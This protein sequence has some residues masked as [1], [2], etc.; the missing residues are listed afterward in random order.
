[1][2]N[3]MNIAP[4]RIRRI[5]IRDYKCIDELEMDFPEPSMSWD[6]D[7]LAMGA[8][9]G[10]GKTAVMECCGWLLLA[11]FSEDAGFAEDE[12]G[13]RM[14]RSSADFYD[15]FVR[16]GCAGA[17]IGGEFVF[18]EFGPDEKR[19]TARI[20]IDRKDGVQV[21]EPVD[22]RDLPAELSNGPAVAR[23]EKSR[24]VEMVSGL[25][26]NPFSGS[27]FLFLHSYRKVREIN[28]SLGEMAGGRQRDSSLRHEPA[29]SAFKLAVLHVLMGRGGVLEMSEDQGPDRSLATLNRLMARYAEGETGKGRACSDDTVDLRVMREGGSGTLSF[30]GLSSGQKEIV[31]A[32]FF[33]WYHTRNTPR[34]VF[35]DEPE[36]H[37]NAQW[38]KRLVRGLEELAPRNQY[39]VATHSEDIMDGIPDNRCR[40][41]SRSESVSA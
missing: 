5:S 15:M 22:R 24:F 38:H 32:L 31:S 33:I 27:L 35:I 6:L 14:R 17:E 4:F 25:T 23:D 3:A 10:V 26:A 13:M 2:N 36:L 9:N 34:I 7:I 8:A 37:L 41:L 20:R 28:P 39:I 21:L 11:A 1:M 18:N 19:V 16:A 40:L 29:P 30:D 12:P